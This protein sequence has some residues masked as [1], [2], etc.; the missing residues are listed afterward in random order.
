MF[1]ANDLFFVC[2]VFGNDEIIKIDCDQTELKLEIWRTCGMQNV[3][4]IVEQ[5][6]AL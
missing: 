6:Y 5:N 2:F 4:F 3:S 1:V